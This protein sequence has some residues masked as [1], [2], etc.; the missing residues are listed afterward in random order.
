MNT[1]QIK[2]DKNSERGGFLAFKEKDRLK[3]WR[4]VG[5]M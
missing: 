2:E 3:D 1:V 4:Q 5:L